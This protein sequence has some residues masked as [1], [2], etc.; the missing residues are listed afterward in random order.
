MSHLLI[1]MSLLLSHNYEI[2]TH[3][4]EILTHI[5]ENRLIVQKQSPF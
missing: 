1:I 4:Y 2:V 5:Y 3:I